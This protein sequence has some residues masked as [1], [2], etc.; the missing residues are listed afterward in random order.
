M[1]CVRIVYSP[2]AIK[3]RNEMGIGERGRTGRGVREREEKRREERE[4]RLFLLFLRPPIF[5]LLLLLCRCRLFFPQL[6][7]FFL[8]F[9]RPPF[10]RRKPSFL[11]TPPPLTPPQ[12]LPSSARVPRRAAL[13][14]STGTRPRPSSSCSSPRPSPPPGGALPARPAPTRR[15]A[16]LSRP[17]S[18]RPSTGEF[19]GFLLFCSLRKDAAPLNAS[20]W[21]GRRR[22]LGAFACVREAKRSKRASAKLACVLLRFAFSFPSFFFFCTSPSTRA[23]STLGSYSSP[24]LPRGAG[25]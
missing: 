1:I 2:C 15:P 23:R 19:E 13:P 11:S 14:R 16:P 25:R 24:S 8:L 17:S 20:A 9:F 3:K 4:K 6:S 18:P 21:R 7:F 22:G 12:W 5:F 10:L